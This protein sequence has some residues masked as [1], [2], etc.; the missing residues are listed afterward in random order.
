M[1]KNIRELKCSELESIL[2]NLQEPSFRAKQ[3]YRWLWKK[4]INSFNEMTNVTEKLRSYLIEN[5]D[6]Q[7]ITIEQKVFSKD[8]T[9]KFLFKLFDGNKCEGVLIP[10][11]NRLTACISSQVGCSFSCKF[12]ATGQMKRIRNI[13]S[14]EIFD[15][16]SLIINESKKEYK[17]SIT[18]IVYMG[19]GEPLVNYQNVVD[20]VK[21]I[22]NKDGLNISSKRIT[23]S[24]VGVSKMIRKLADEE[25]KINLA[26]SLHSANNVKRTKIM[27]INSVNDLDDLKNAL[28]YFFNK[29]KIKI[30]YEYIMLKDFNDTKKDALDLIK[31]CKIIPS[32]VNLIEFNTVKKTNFMKS[33]DIITKEFIEILKKE[34]II[35]NLRKSRGEDVNA[36]CGQLAN[37]TD[38]FEKN[39]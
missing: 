38:N 27:D 35:V 17:K 26:V 11:K 29:T 31:F 20:S 39:H 19:M 30:T 7:Y 4:R 3:I 28:I 36:A 22:I 5:F 24:T 10:D 34:K 16:V 33:S 15:Q 8:G 32:K 21:Y 37:T 9:I 6:I 18:N 23:L 13:M 14:Y 25:L 12:C 2:T 1:K